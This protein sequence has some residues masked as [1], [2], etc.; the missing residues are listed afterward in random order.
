MKTSIEPVA[1]TD[2]TPAKNLVKVSV[3]IPEAEFERDIDAAFRKIAREVKLPGFRAGKAPRKV[4]EA[5]I[6]MAAA[7]D[8]ALRDAVPEYLA[9]AVRQLDVDLIATPNVALTGGEESG[10][11]EFDATC[12]VRPQVTVPG[13]GALRITVPSPDAS[14]DEVDEAV[15][16]ERTR[17]GS[18]ESVT[19]P[20]ELGDHVTLTLSATRDGEPVPGLSVDEWVYELGKGWV[21]EG[22]DDQFVGRHAGDDLQFTLTPS[23][24]T[25]PAD[26]QVTLDSVQQMLLP[27]LTDEWV[28]DHLGGFDTVQAWRQSL[29]EGI[30]NR[31]LTEVRNQFV[32]LLTDALAE[33]VEDDAPEAMV[34]A[35][36]QGRVQNIARQFQAQG[37]DLQQWLQA[38]GQ[39]V[40]SFIETVRPQ[41]VKAAKVDLALRAVADAEAIELT[42]DDVEAEYRQ[43]AVRYRQKVGEVRKAYEKNDAVTDLVAEIRKAKALDWLVHHAE[44]VDPDGLALDRDLII[45]HTHDDHDHDDHAHDHDHDDHDHDHHDHDGHDHDHKGEDH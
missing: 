29:A 37:I 22:F 35:D 25:E 42:D 15:D 18:L 43:L 4:L 21:A 36:L 3:S 6:G 8:Q 41:S 40:E 33:L 24:T 44:V 17:Q 34:N 14:G 11:V 2:E 32:D 13:Y 12:E 5:R 28:A 30:S 9:K 38:T 23:G 19:R 45:G 39:N 27:E 10:P 26:F 1:P 7:R 16:A 31:K 20:A